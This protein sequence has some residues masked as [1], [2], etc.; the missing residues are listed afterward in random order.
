MQLG[1]RAA[2]VIAYG[3]AAL[4][5]DARAQTIRGT[6]GEEREEVEPVGL[7]G[8]RVPLARLLRHAMREAP[9][10]AVARAQMQLADEAFGAADPLLPNPTIS[11]AAGPRFGQGGATDADVEVSLE[12]PVEIAGQRPARFDV[13]RAERHTREQALQQARWE[14][15]QRVH[16]GYRMAILARERATLARRIA[17]FRRELVEI[18]RRRVDA[19]E[20]APLELR[21]AEAEA[22]QAEQ[23]AIAA[24]QS[25]R[26]AC[27]ALAEVAGWSA[28]RPP[29]PLGAPEA[30]LRA[31]PLE[32]LLEL[33]RA[34]DPVL[35]V[36]R[37][38]VDAARARLALADREAW[39]TPS[40]G[41][42]YEREGAP[43]GIA[44]DS[45]LAVVTVPI[46]AFER[47]Q[48]ERARSAAELD[49]ATA[50]H[51]ARI[52]VLAA[53]LEGLRTAVDAA[54]ARVA[55]YGDDILPRFAETLQQL[56]RAFEL[57]EIDVLQLSVALER[58]LS[59]QLEALDAYADY[60]NAVAALEAEVGVEIASP[61]GE[62]G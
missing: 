1:A 28:R 39:P 23:R 54:V 48:A 2:A 49:V 21:L 32:R 24:L 41:A 57:G 10:I 38:A 22:A 33:A 62:R 25:Y 55:A 56:R 45:V 60:A 42:R 17:R 36:R 53:R 43:G 61:G 12:V 16:A 51:E 46:P 27:L 29:E 7:G 40:L 26:R 44:Q 59:I 3:L 11:A 15:H 5:V 8:I 14:V 37:A 50:E 4:A 52:A 6:E 58:F 47:N 19:G 20:S 18:A 9:A 30:A 35:G 13:A 34:H 31:P